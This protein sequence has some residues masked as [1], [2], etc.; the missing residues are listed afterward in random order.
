MGRRGTRNSKRCRDARPGDLGSGVSCVRNPDY[1]GSCGEV[2]VERGRSGRPWPVRRALE[3]RMMACG[4]VWSSLEEG[5]PG[6]VQKEIPIRC[7]LGREEDSA[8]N[9]RQEVARQWWEAP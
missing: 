8:W 5:R 4:G 2:P 6:G 9:D 1:D 3:A 7:Y